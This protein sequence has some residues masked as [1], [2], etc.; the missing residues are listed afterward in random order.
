MAATWQSVLEAVI[1]GLKK[2]ERSRCSIAIGNKTVA[3]VMSNP[4][5]GFF[6]N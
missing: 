3:F 5:L 1:E 2:F 6:S 4:V